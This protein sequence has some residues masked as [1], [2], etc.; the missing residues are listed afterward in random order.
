MKT[1]N[2]ILIG[3]LVSFFYYNLFHR[4]LRDTYVTWEEYNSK[5]VV[6]SKTLGGDMYLYT[7][8]PFPLGETF[9]N[10]TVRAKSSSKKDLVAA[11]R[12]VKSDQTGLKV[13]SY[14]AE[15]ISYQI[16]STS[17]FINIPENMSI[18]QPIIIYGPSPT[19]ITSDGVDHL[20]IVNSHFDKALTIIST[21]N[22]GIIQKSRHLAGLVLKEVSTNGLTL[23]TSQAS[24][25]M[26]GHLNKHTTIQ[27]NLQKSTFL[28]VGLVSNELTIDADSMS[29]VTFTRPDIENQIKPDKKKRAYLLLSKIDHLILRGAP[30]EVDLKNTEI[31]RISGQVNPSTVISGTLI[32]M[33]GLMP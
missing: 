16:K 6:G 31:A 14:Y 23:N 13:A 18:S 10:I 33:T 2:V 19:A 1:S 15:K 12:W 24:L 8:M 5:Q 29:R 32:D 22:G 20:E 9:S 17:L 3:I 7:K 30:Q 28:A 26:E 21:D 27:A 11:I 4:M 25:T